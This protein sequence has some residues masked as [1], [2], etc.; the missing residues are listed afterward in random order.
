MVPAAPKEAEPCQGNG[1]ENHEGD[2]ADAPASLR[3]YVDD[4][5]LFVAGQKKKQRNGWLTPS[6]GLAFVCRKER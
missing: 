1:D 2:A 6:L 5:R 3:T 4:W